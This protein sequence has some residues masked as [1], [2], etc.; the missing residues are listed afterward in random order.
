M[1]FR[2][3]LIKKN[4]YISVFKNK[5]KVIGCENSKNYIELS[6]NRIEKFTEMKLNTIDI[7]TES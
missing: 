1:V 7:N 3:N 5:R 2:K 4:V 6:I